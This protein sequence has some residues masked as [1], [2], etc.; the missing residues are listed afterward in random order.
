L[1]HGRRRRL[2]RRRRRRRW[3]RRRRRRD[4]VD[5]HLLINNGLL[6]DLELGLKKVIGKTQVERDSDADPYPK[7]RRN[8]LAFRRIENRVPFSM[9]SFFHT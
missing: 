3:W 5:V 8:T 1:N 9:G 4:E 6:V 7:R 2:R